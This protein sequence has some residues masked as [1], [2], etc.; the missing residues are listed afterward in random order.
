VVSGKWSVVVEKHAIM[1]FFDTVGTTGA[2]PE[3]LSRALF[4]GGWFFAAGLLVPLFRGFLLYQA[5]LSDGIDL[6][7]F[8]ACYYLTFVWLAALVVVVATVRGKLKRI[9][10]L[11]AGLLTILEIISFWVIAQH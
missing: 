6:L 8:A 3:R 11:Q 5:D 4:A 1:P 9:L 10:W 7:V 2:W